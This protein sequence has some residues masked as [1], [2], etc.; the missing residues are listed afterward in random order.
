MPA[1]GRLAVEATGDWTA[2]ATLKGTIR[3]EQLSGTA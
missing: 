1:N 2:R 3:S